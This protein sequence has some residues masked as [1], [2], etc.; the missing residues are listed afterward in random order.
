MLAYLPTRADI[1]TATA[2]LREEHLAQ[3]RAMLSP[4]Y[5]SREH[6][7]PVLSTSIRRR[8]STVGR[9]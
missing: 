2:K 6:C 7:L 1:E 8:E 4:H 5:E 9:I 3:K